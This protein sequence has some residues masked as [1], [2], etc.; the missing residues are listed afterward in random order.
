MP[1]SFW[2][3]LKVAV[4]FTLLAS[5]LHPQ[6]ASSQSGLFW[7]VVKPGT[8]DTSFLLGTLHKYPK[9]VVEVPPVVEEKLADCRTLF[10][11]MQLDWKMVLKMLTGGTLNNEMMIDE[12]QE[13]TS[14]DWD[15]IKSWFVEKQGM[16]EAEYNRIKSSG[17]T[18]RLA[19]LYLSLYG[20]KYGEVE[21]DLKI[22]AKRKKI[23]IKGL[24]KDWNEI[25]SWYAHYAQSSSGFWQEGKLDSMLTD[26][27][28]SLA[29]MFISYAV[30]DTTTL[31]EIDTDDHW[32]DGLSLVEW[33]NI[34]WMKQLPQLMENRTFV[35]VGAAH[36][37]GPNGVVQLLRN[38]GFACYPV[39]GHFGGEKLERFIRR[40]S[41]QYQLA[42]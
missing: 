16:E 19:D 7:S 22:W 4:V 23:P 41:R 17:T 25:Q 42:D 1:L 30:Q 12:N 34:N 29:D 28:Y 9:S 35:A 6:K 39:E 15:Q 26:G 8:R 32:K 18:S 37:Y 3:N 10:L 40:N 24:D 13:W 38:Q 33:R 31:G 11:E 27:Y 5:V 14:E 21:S 2:R 36:L 20:Y